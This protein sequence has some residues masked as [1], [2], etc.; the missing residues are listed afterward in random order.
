MGTTNGATGNGGGLSEEEARE[1]RRI[2]RLLKQI[3]EIAK[4]ASL[5]GALSE[6]AADGVERYNLIVRHLEDRG[7][8]SGPFF[9]P[10]PTD[11]SFDRVG[12][13]CK[14]LESYLSEET[15]DKDKS[16]GGGGGSVIH[17]GNLGNVA[18][19]D[20]LRDLGKIIRENLPEFLRDKERREADAAAARADRDAA[21]PFPSGDLG[22]APTVE[23]REREQQ[24]RS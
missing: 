13:A 23:Q 5:T 19:L 6:G 4:E 16:R 15:E 22:T 12:V 24:R 2:R 18:D 9:P 3:G 8:L 21:M 17:I 20:Q 10:L 14:L 7:V 11:A 1:L